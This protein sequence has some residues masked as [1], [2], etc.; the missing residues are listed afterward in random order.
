MAGILSALLGGGSSRYS[1]VI[2]KGQF[3]IKGIYQTGYRYAPNN[4]GII[5]PPDASGIS[6]VAQAP[7]SGIYYD[8]TSTY[9]G[10][11]LLGTL[12]TS[13]LSFL[14]INGTDR[15]LGTGYTGNS[16][17]ANCTI[18]IATPCVV[19]SVG[20][21]GYAGLPVSFTTTGAL[22]TGLTVGTVYYMRNVT[23]NTFELGTTPNAS[24]SIATSGTQSGTH[25][26]LNT[27][28][29]KF[30]CTTTGD[31]I[32]STNPGAAGPYTVTMTIANPCVV[33]WT[34]HGQAN[35]QRVVLRTT[36][37]LPTGLSANTVYYVVNAT[38]NTFQLATTAGGAAIA[39]SGTQ[40]GT[41]T[42]YQAVQIDIR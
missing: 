18:S 40:S 28:Y 2:G 1:L 7:L 24:T 25:T 37:A 36:G 30:D 31:F 27:P 23:T 20:H 10:V 34:S 14:T 32:G 29:T 5:A 21:G 16:G 6:T 13:L 33:T 11:M 26:F 39:T 15:A 12:S 4:Y 19:A 17:S 22:P 9:T 41:H 8:S 38:A 42:I 35:G 3:S